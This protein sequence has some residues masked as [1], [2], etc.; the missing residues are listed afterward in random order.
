MRSPVRLI[1]V[2]LVIVA[3]ILGV[4]FAVASTTG[5]API[6]RVEKL[7][8][9]QSQAIPNFSD[10]THT[11]SDPAKIALFTALTTRYSIDT[12]RFPTSLNDVCTGGLAT[13]ITLYSPDAATQR[14]RI[15]DCGLAVA[16]GTFVTDATALFVGWRATD[17]PR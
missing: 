3:V 17:A 4:F 10:T 2:F 1:A 16:K 14:L 12:A 9:R 13:D 5:P 7:T 15:Y 6:T 11:V 8:F